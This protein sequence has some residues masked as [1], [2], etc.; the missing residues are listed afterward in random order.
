MQKIYNNIKAQPNLKI[1]NILKFEITL[2]NLLKTAF[3]YYFVVKKLK[4]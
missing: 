3:N 1:Q 4:K 2:K